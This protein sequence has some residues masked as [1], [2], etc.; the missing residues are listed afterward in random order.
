MLKALEDLCQLQA[1]DSEIDAERARVTIIDASLQDRSEFETAKQRHL[2]AAGPVKA[3]DA[4]ARDLELKIGSARSQLAEAD[5]KLYS[6]KVN[7]PRELNDLQARSANL[8]RQI[9]V[10]EAAEL[11]VMERLDTA[12]EELTSAEAA[13]RQIVADRK[14]FETN[15]IAER[16]ELV[17]TIRSTTARRDQ[18]RTQL[19]APILR[20]YDR[21]RTRYGGLALAEVKQRTCQGCRVSL[22]AALEQRLRQGEQLVTCQSCGRFLYVTS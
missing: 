19:E 17:S 10:G 8:R 18:V 20:S 4:E 2:V 12:R 21:L 7:N 22:V 13:L 14:V 11:T 1:L 15:L 6:G 5:Q 9:E 16:K 3:L